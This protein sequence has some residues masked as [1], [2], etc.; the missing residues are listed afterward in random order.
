MPAGI[1]IIAVGLMAI[2]WGGWWA[3][4]QLRRA[5]ERVAPQG[6]ERYDRLMIPVA[7]HRMRRLS[8]IV[9]GAAVL[10]GMVYLLM[11]L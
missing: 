8:V 10:I 2:S 11:E 6:R 7:M 4:R 1:L 9:G 3:P 5:E